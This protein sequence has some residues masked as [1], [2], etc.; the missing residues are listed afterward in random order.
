MKKI[1]ITL[2]DPYGI[3]PETTFKALKK[4]KP[5]KAEFTLIGDIEN[6]K[7]FGELKGA[8]KYLNIKSSFRAPAEP[9]ASKRGGDISFKALKKAVDL[10]T[11]QQA[12]A[13]VT[14]P[15][16]KEAWRKAGVKYM[17]HTEFLRDK[18]SAQGALM[19]FKSGKL[20]CALI[21]EH[22]AIK[23]LS[24][25][26]SKK[27]VKNAAKILAGQL[28]PGAAIEVSALNPHCGDGGKIGQEE[29]QTII[30]AVKELKKEG[31]NI[32][33]PY[34]IDALWLRHKK[35]LSEAV[36]ITYHDAALLGLKL[37]A[38][39]PVVHITAGLKFL[40]VSPAHGTAFD[41]AGKNRAEEYSMLAAIKYALS[42]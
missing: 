6:F 39:E 20:T 40:R 13:L 34:P 12:D 1:I 29:I 38:K 5:G 32:T 3:G 27:R 14:A 10:M 24:S 19:M 22:Y 37:A 42:K 15:I 7:K 16:S 33:G 18:A 8:L 41:I 11:E 26:L 31:L 28:P 30:P 36:L 23:D 21:T 2:G 4:I 17:G 9:K 25:A 35:G